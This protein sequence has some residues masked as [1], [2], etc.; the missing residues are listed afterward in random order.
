M[1]VSGDIRG[2][3]DDDPNSTVKTVNVEKGD[4]YVMGDVAVNG[5]VVGSLSSKNDAKLWGDLM[6]SYGEMYIAG[7][8]WLNRP[9]SDLSTL[10]INAFLGYIG[11][12]LHANQ[13]C[14]EITDGTLECAALDVKT[15]LQLTGKMVIARELTVG[16]TFTMHESRASVGSGSTINH[17]SVDGYAVLLGGK[18]TIFNNLELEGP[19]STLVLMGAVDAAWTWMHEDAYMIVGGSLTT[20]LLEVAG[21][22]DVFAGG[23][24]IVDGNLRGCDVDDIPDALTIM[25]GEEGDEIEGYLSLLVLGTMS[26]NGT[27]NVT[28]PMVIDGIMYM[29]GT[30]TVKGKVTVLGE[31][32]IGAY[33]PYAGVAGDGLFILAA[34]AELYVAGEERDEDGQLIRGYGEIWVYGK[35]DA[36]AVPVDKVVNDGRIWTSS[37]GRHVPPYGSTTL[38]YKFTVLTGD[39]TATITPGTEG[40]I[41]QGADFTLTIAHEYGYSLKSVDVVILNTNGSIKR[42]LEEGVDF[43]F[44]SHKVVILGSSLD[45]VMGDVLIT[46]YDSYQPTDEDFVIQVVLLGALLLGLLLTLWFLG[47]RRKKKAVKIKRYY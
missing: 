16:G 33:G 46:L 5:L 42:T 24:V 27:L 14:V 20:G 26:M 18:I 22:M 30:S 32:N 6:I 44:S 19:G 41:Q 45:G 12:T 39:N 23:T 31:L 29:S 43:I 28:G 8:L 10:D 15:D 1:L 17:L 21:M 40:P 13:L 11:G 35:L 36:S 25:G 4:L 2:T 38:S 37:G 7:D 47:T 9:A 34:G 3:L